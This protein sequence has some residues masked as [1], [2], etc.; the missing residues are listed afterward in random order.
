VVVAIRSRRS[1]PV[2]GYGLLLFLLFLAPTSSFIPIRD[3][4]AERRMYLPMLGL[5]LMVLDVLHRSNLS[6]RAISGVA[7]T[8]L[9]LLGSGTHQR[10]MAWGDGGRLWESAIAAAPEK[11]R[12]YANLASLHLAKRNCTGALDVIHRAESAVR[13]MRDGYLL[14]AWSLSLEC[15]GDRNGAIQKMREAVAVQPSAQSYAALGR[16]YVAT[17]ELADAERSLNAAERLD[18]RWEVTYIYRALLDVDRGRPDLATE[19]LGRALSINP[20]NRQAR[21]LLEQTR[22]RAAE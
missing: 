11:S 2:L 9:L 4:A 10:A 19:E 13:D 3:V 17:G 6:E 1:R 21:Q 16:M 14:A 8:V 18:P 7:G 5:L 12:P 22:S 15:T 20:A